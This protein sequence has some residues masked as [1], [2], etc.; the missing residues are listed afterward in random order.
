MNRIHLARALLILTAAW[1]ATVTRAADPYTNTPDADET[2]A[3]QHLITQCYDEYLERPP[4]A[5]GL[6]TYT[7]YLLKEGKNEEWLREMLAASPEHQAV[8]R[9]HQQNAQRRTNLRLAGLVLAIALPLSILAARKGL[10]NSLKRRA[11]GFLNAI[12]TTQAKSAVHFIFRH[13]VLLIGAVFTVCVL[14]EWHGYSIGLW[15]EFIREKTPDYSFF[16]VGKNRAIRSDEW[17]VSTPWCLAQTQTIPRFP[18]VNH[19]LYT[20][21]MYMSLCTPNAPVLNAT[22]IGQA[23]H[24]GFF[25]FGPARGLAWNFGIRYLGLFLLA[26]EFFLIVLQRNRLLA[27]SGALMIVLASPTQWW[28]TTVPYHLLYFFGCCVAFWHLLRPNHPL[29]TMLWTVLFLVCLSSFLLLPYPPF[30]L[31]LLP[32][33]ALVCF[34]FIRKKQEPFFNA[35]RV[36]SLSAV[37][38]VL[39]VVIGRFAADNGAGLLQLAQTVYPGARVATG[40]DWTQLDNLIKP[41]LSLYFPFREPLFSNA[42]E[43]SMFLVPFPALLLMTPRLLRRAKKGLQKQLFILFIALGCLLMAWGLFQWP[44]WAARMSLL[45]LIPASRAWVISGFFLQIATLIGLFLIHRD[46]LSPGPRI[47]MIIAG[48]TACVLPVY[49]LLNRAA[50]GYYFPNGP[51]LTGLFLAG[52]ATL[53][54][55]LLNA[56]LL[57]GHIRLFSTALILYSLIAGTTVHPLSR[58]ISPIM[59]KQL[60][61]TARALQAQNPSAKWIEIGAWPVF[62]QYLTALGLPVITGVHAVPNTRFWRRLD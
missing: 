50:Y 13:R 20:D 48:A 15:D 51:S 2:A 24:W 6:A 14:L 25:L 38:L 9:L 44:V 58:G 55:A 29:K 47:S 36:I 53:L 33:M 27:F 12:P 28:D 41:L 46:H 61:V 56:G 5:G 60:A 45:Y 43:M 18:S 39:L 4:D 49:L 23:H 54:F 34:C 35:T 16:S 40:G 31:P 52:G 3:V 30:Q 8:L 59:D 7:R 10:F 22:A 32:A 26:L 11:D 17:L 19:R 37:L 62:S 57:R 42:C 1:S 21:G